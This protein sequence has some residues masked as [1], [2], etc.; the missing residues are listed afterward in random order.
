MANQGVRAKCHRELN[1]E[2]REYIASR[3][4]AKFRYM[5]IP[6]NLRL[7]IYIGLTT[8]VL[9]LIPIWLLHPSADSLNAVRTIKGFYEFDGGKSPAAS[10]VTMIAGEQIFCMRDFSGDGRACPQ[11][12]KGK[13]VTAVIGSFRHLFGSGE[14]TLEIVATDGDFV[15]Y[16]PT[17]ILKDWLRSSLVS[18]MLNAFMLSLVACIFFEIFSIKRK[19]K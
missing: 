13:T 14:I 9:Q 1:I 4:D 7:S 2:E 8:F 17:Q 12:F 11:R 5:N 3:L 16:S 19:E 6:K 18:A 15:R 10:P